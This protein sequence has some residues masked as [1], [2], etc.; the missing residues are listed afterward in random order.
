MKG[1]AASLYLAVISSGCTSGSPVAPPPTSPQAVI[2]PS[3]LVYRQIS[4]GQTVTG[5]LEGNGSKA[6]FVLTAPSNGTL[7]VTVS[8]DSKDGIVELVLGPKRF[9]YEL[10][11]PLSGRLAVVAGQKYLVTIVDAAAWDYH[12]LH[13]PYTLRSSID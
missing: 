13:L 10:G 1:F 8:W 6:F 12:G 3:P 5:A 7:T 9:G 11:N 4:A 2:S